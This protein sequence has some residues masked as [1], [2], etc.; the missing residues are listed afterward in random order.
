MV[1]KNIKHMLLFVTLCILLIGIVS[2]TDVESNDTTE[3]SQIISEK[4]VESHESTSDVKENVIND[5]KEIK[6]DTKTENVKT[7]TNKVKTKITI[8]PIINIAVDE[9]VIIIGKCTDINNNPL[10]Y[11]PVK[12]DVNGEAYNT[13]TDYYGDYYGEYI[14]SM[15]GKKTVT[16]SFA[17]NNNYA[18][19]TAKTTF[20]VTG[21]ATTYININTIQDTTIGNTIKI[22]GRYYY[23]H[24]TPLTYTNMTFNING[25]KYYNKTD[26]NGYFSYS[27]KT[28]KEGTNKVTV[29]YPGNTKFKA[30]SSTTT[31]NVK[32]K[33]PQ[34]TYITLN[35]IPEVSYGS[36][37]TINGH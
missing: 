26:A 19:S 16:V 32:P 2:A 10:R 3:H 23:S 28:N 4:T 13:E 27:Y 37:T 25:V 1:N 29:S 35:N 6:K 34:Y 17:G 18:A 30:A 9:G 22:T 31:F 14:A 33:G 21:K 20:N 12:L 7:A 15:P 5:N 36:Y 11:T 8:D 24:A